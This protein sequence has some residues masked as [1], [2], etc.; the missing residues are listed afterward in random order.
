M[1]QH[2]EAKDLPIR[3]IEDTDYDEKG[4]SKGNFWMSF[5]SDVE[6]SFTGQ[7]GHELYG[8]VRLRG[9]L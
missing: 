4:D 3:V 2:P 8:E 7:S 5:D 1:E 6:V 9:S